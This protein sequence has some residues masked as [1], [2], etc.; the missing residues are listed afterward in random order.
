M[1][2]RDVGEVLPIS[3]D[4]DPVAKEKLVKFALP[5]LQL[6]VVHTSVQW[7]L[8]DLLEGGEVVLFPSNALINISEVLNEFLDGDLAVLGLEAH[9]AWESACRRQAV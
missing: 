8:F 2:D 5:L 9:V 7:V 1:L 3:L 6:A 4:L